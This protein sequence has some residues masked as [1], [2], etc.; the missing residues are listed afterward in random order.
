MLAAP[1]RR[2]N[3]PASRNGA[4]VEIHSGVNSDAQPGLHRAALDCPPN[5]AK[6]IGH[7]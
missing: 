7:A 4:S 3:Q 5:A 1:E 2:L 6:P